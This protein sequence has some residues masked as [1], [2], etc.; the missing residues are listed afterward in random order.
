ML[1]DLP[2][3][4]EHVRLHLASSELPEERH[5]RTIPAHVAFNLT[6][7]HSHLSGE[8]LIDMNPLPMHDSP[9]SAEVE[10]HV[11]SVWLEHDRSWH[12]ERQACL[13]VLTEAP[14][15]RGSWHG[16]VRVFAAHT[17]CVSCLACLVQTWCALQP[18]VKV[19]VHFDTWESAYAACVSAVPVLAGLVEPCP[20]WRADWDGCSSSNE[21]VG[22]P[23]CVRDW[24]ADWDDVDT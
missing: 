13:H 9:W 22:F 11:S 23:D 6:D 18:G 15:C 1:C 12:A 24:R 14:Q 5:W 19:L 2:E 21:P 16:S 17:P 8:K 10:T 7:G 4:H 20:D 3:A